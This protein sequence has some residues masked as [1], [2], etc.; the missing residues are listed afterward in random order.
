VPRISNTATD[1]NHIL[2]AAARARRA[3]LAEPIALLAS[4]SSGMC[5][6]NVLQSGH[7]K[8]EGRLLGKTPG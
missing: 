4:G 1:P 8:D 6:G 5:C 3:G 7:L 2:K